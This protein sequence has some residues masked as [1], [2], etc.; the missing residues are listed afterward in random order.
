[1]D[2]VDGA[3]EPIL[4]RGGAVVTAA[5]GFGAVE[6]GGAAPLASASGGRDV[7]APVASPADWSDQVVRTTVPDSAAS[8]TLALT[9]AGGRRLTATVHVLPHVVFSP[10]TLHWDSLGTFPLAPVGVALAAAEIPSGTGVVTTLYAAGGAEQISGALVPDSGVYVARALA[11]GPVGPW[12]RQHD[13]ADF[14]SRVLPAP[15]AFAAAAVA[16]R[17]NSRFAGSRRYPI[18]GIHGARPPQ[19]SRFSADRHADSVVWRL[20]PPE[21]LPPP[22]A[23]ALAV[24]AP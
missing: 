7:T 12:V 22:V 13:A 2:C 4:E 18:G 19:A 10:D 8:G 20:T 16:P 1:M 24:A 23:R 3:L 21:P 14:T 6:G 17:H 11:A 15:R 5:L 9:T